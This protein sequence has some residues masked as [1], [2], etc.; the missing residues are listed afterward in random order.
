MWLLVSYLLY[1]FSRAFTA[2]KPAVMGWLSKAPNTDQCPTAHRYLR[3]PCTYSRDQCR[4]YLGGPIS[5]A[6][7]DSENRVICKRNLSDVEP[8]V[9]K[10]SVSKNPKRTIKSGMEV[11]WSYNLGLHDK[12]HPNLYPQN[13]WLV[14]SSTCSHNLNLVRP[15]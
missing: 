1:M 10:L 12:L 5:L 8:W 11:L 3:S 9:H 7:F 15:S 13:Q 2:G 4:I 14:V 6:N